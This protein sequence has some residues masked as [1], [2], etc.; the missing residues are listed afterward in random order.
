MS[1]PLEE[2]T[3]GTGHH[4]CVHHLPKDFGV[5]G[6]VLGVF[7]PEGGMCVLPL[8]CVCTPGSVQTCT[9]A[10]PGAGHPHSRLTF[11]TC[12]L[13]AHRSVGGFK[14]PLCHPLATDGSFL[15]ASWHRTCVCSRR[16][17]SVGNPYSVIFIFS[18]LALL[19]LKPLLLSARPPVWVTALV[20]DDVFETDSGTA[21][22]ED[23]F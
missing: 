9:L 16:A 13:H 14:E 11:R 23:A 19:F 4:D 8:G 21:G 7:C 6:Y 2:P 3:V 18:K 12:G 22:P 10:S 20:F 1:S 17:V 5:I 15:P